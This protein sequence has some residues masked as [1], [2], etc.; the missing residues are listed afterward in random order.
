MNHI[1]CTAVLV[2]CG[3]LTNA[4]EEALLRDEGYQ[5]KLAAVIAS[6]WLTFGPVNPQEEPGPDGG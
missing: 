3:F 2:E 5:R 6:A 1:D 4:A